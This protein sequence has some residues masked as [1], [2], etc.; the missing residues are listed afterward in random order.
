M[1]PPC[2]V[3]NDSYEKE[4]AIIRTGTQWTLLIVFLIL[5][6][7]V[8]F[9]PFVSRFILRV[10]ISN[11]IILIAVIGI[12][13][14]TGYCGQITLGQAGFVVVGAYTSAL[15]TSEF[16]MSFWI[17]LPCAGIA[18]TLLGLIFALPA[19]RV[20]GLYLALIT[21]AALVIIFWS[22][23]NV[24]TMF[25]LPWGSVGLTAPAPKLGSI[26]FDSIRSFYYIAVPTTV[27]MVFFAKSIA[28]SGL[29]RA[30][31]A[32]RDNDKAA[33]AIGINI[34]RYKLIAFCIC[35]FYAGIAGSLFAH[36]YGWIGSESFH[37]MDSVWWI[38]MAIIG[39]LGTTMGPI[40]G[41]I[42]IAFLT[43]AMLRVGPLVEGS[44]PFLGAGAGGGFAIFAYGLVILLFLIFEPRGLAHR[45]GI[46]K[47]Q[48]RLWPY[49]Y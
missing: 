38:G 14:V 43:E 1:Y 3:Y 47:S 20:R 37:L 6:F 28:R 27:L 5:L 29:G 19:L 46:F 16:G 42:F 23:R 9:L 12:N 21:L 48:Y 22:I 17:A 2:G 30:F 41:T 45:W 36:Y 35:S 26:V 31:V 25:G 33:E 11:A 34:F 18:A 40:F 8:P 39:G 4:M 32:V 49:A 15:L 24:P 13:I 44:V 7:A 10:I